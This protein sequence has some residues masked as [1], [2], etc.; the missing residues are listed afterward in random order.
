MTLPPH[1]RAEVQRI[2]DGAARRLL[3]DELN[4]QPLGTA[5]GI[6]GDALDRRPDQRSTLMEG[7]PT[8]VLAGDGERTRAA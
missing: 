8:P 3:A 4:G 6:D 7:E 5:T 1:A 2:L